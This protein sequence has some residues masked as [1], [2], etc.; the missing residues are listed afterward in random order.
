MEIKVA[1]TH[2]VKIIWMKIGQFIGLQKEINF[3]KTH[4]KSQQKIIFLNTHIYIYI[5][6]RR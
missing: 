2:T 1:S 5:A 6:L 3:S 4:G